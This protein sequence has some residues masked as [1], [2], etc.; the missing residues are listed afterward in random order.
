MTDR[1]TTF[2]DRLK[3]SGSLIKDLLLDEIVVK[4]EIA[5]PL[6]SDFLECEV[7][8]SRNSAERYLVLKS[9]GGEATVFVTLDETAAKQL[10]DFIQQSFLKPQDQ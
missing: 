6:G 7:R 10:V 1:P 2:L 9:R 8:Q 3:A 4:S 5:T